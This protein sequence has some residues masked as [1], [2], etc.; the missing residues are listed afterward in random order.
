MSAEYT[1]H[2]T[3]RGRVQGVFFRARARDAA[4]RLG[5]RGWVRNLP[6]GAVETM[7]RGPGG[8]I[9]EYL[10]WCRRGPAAARVNRVEQHELP[11]AGKTIDLGT[12]FKVLS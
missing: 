12:D 6:D 3:I 8:A 4:R 11:T 10:G 2:L 1:I 5:L 7:A 9:A